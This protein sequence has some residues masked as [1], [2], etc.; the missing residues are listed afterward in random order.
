[1]KI[2]IF[3]IFYDKKYE[4][5]G[6]EKGMPIEIGTNWPLMAITPPKENALQK[7][8]HVNVPANNPKASVILDKGTELESNTF[9]EKGTFLDFYI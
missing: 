3:E 6:K 5:S 2:L 1:V 7:E 9:W 8:T 4:G